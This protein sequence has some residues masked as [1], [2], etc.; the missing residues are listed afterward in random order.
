MLNSNSKDDDLNFQNVEN[1]NDHQEEK[2]EIIPNG[3]NFK[4]L[5]EICDN[6]YDKL[7]KNDYFG[8]KSSWRTYSD[9]EPI[10]IKIESVETILGICDIIKPKNNN[11]YHKVLTVFG[12]IILDVDKLLP[13][14]GTT[15][16]ESLY[17]LSVYGEE[18]DTGKD[19]KT[20][21]DA[22]I[23]ISRMLP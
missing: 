10:K 2:E 18:F 22:E 1:L 13:N 20:K 5:S 17:C 9:I 8:H 6:F 16:Y 15:I 21:N 4:I 14:I 23:Q 7:Q 3:H 11:F 12:I 19:E